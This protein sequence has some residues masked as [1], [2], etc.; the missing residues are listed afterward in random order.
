MKTL[1]ERL[2]LLRKKLGIKQSQLAQ[3][4][5]GGEA[6]IKAMEQGRT[7]TIKPKYAIALE[8]KLKINRVWLEHG[9]GDM[10]KSEFGDILN[11]I[12]KLDSHLN[13]DSNHCPYY[14]DIADTSYIAH[15]SIPIGILK[16]PS[17]KLLAV[18]INNDSMGETLQSGDI[19]FINMDDTDIISGK[20]YKIKFN[21][22]VILKRIYKK[23]DNLF[24]LKED[25]PISPQ[26]DAKRADF[27]VLG[28]AVATINIKLLQ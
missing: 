10:F 4:M 27:K 16:N 6:T 1:A 21:S 13:S 15:V 12:A 22:E 14:E 24:L 8:D 7:L 28:R 9:K 2:K 3:Y 11:S 25:N 17:K 23:T 20:I 18:K 26:L 19:V 5:E